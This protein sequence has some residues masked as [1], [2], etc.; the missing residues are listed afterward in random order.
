M[1]NDS[2]DDTKRDRHGLIKISVILVSLF[3]GLAIAE[4]GLRLFF[5]DSLGVVLNDER[6]V[7]Y[8]Y[9]PELGWF[10]K[11]N[12]D[13]IFD[14]AARRI[15]V[16]SNS[17]GFRDIEHK[18]DERPVIL[19]LGDSFVWGY[20][21]EAEERFT[22]RLREK[23][24]GWNI[25]NLGVS[26]YGTDQELL[27]LKKYIGFYKPKVVFLVICVGNDLHD[28]ASNMRYGYFKP[29][30]DLSEKGMVLKGVPVSKNLT[31][32]VRN[33]PML[34][35]LWTLRLVRVALYPRLVFNDDPN[36]REIINIGKKN[37]TLHLLREMKKVADLH[38]ARF[39]VGLEQP[40]REIEAS[41]DAD[42][43]PYTQ[44]FTIDR[45]MADGIHWT[46]EGHLKVAEM[47]HQ[48]L[49]DKGIGRR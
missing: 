5:A 48:F 30:F 7:V 22:E 23:M 24:P 36:A 1:K 11:E 14:G 3:A 26:G 35:R 16:K 19:F 33:H 12:L 4:T 47:I 46:P 2:K 10:P 45:Y 40:H 17:L 13:T 31:Y 15:H 49:S 32:F 38:G 18:V 28:N 42:G 8:R 21:V 34:S 9:D 29:Y 39:F 25:L 6:G 44:L 43:I 37:P 20:D 27:L 41:L